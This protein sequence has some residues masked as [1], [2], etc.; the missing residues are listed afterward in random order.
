MA[1]QYRVPPCL[2]SSSMLAIVGTVFGSPHEWAYYLCLQYRRPVRY[3]NMN[4][5][6]PARVQCT[7]ISVCLLL[8][9]LRRLVRCVCVASCTLLVGVASCTLLALLTLPVAFHAVPSDVLKVGKPLPWTRN[10][11]CP[12]AK[13]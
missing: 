8:L 7:D 1:H 10:H 2:V 9:L 3:S 11:L 5:W 6:A 12:S 4:R 13:K